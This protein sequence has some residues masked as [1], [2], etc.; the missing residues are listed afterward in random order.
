SLAL[1]VPI[2]KVKGM[3]GTLARANAARN[4]K[5]TSTT[6]TALIIGIALVGFITIFAASAKAS[7]SHAIDSQFKTDYII[8]AGAG[9]G[10][11]GLSPELAKQ[12]SQ[13]PEIQA[14]T[15]LRGVNSAIDG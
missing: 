3:T 14:V 9:F 11:G 1:G 15:G 7:V 13:L 8:R 10:A 5:R 12:M 2:A 6:A 4:P